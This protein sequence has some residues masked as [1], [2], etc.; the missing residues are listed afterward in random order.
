MERRNEKSGGKRIEPGQEGEREQAARPLSDDNGRRQRESTPL[1]G[2]REWG[3]KCI[4]HP[5]CGEGHIP[6]KCAAFKRL[7][8]A[9]REALAEV[10]GRCTRCYHSVG[11]GCGVHKSCNPPSKW[12]MPVKPAVPEVPEK[13]FPKVTTKEGY[14]SYQC[15]ITVKLVR[16][17]GEPEH[18]VNSLHV[19][20]EV[21][22]EDTVLTSS[23]V[24]SAG[25][26]TC[27]VKAKEVY[28]PLGKKVVSNLMAIFSLAGVKGEPIAVTAYVIEPTM[29]TP[30]KA[31]G[32][33]LL[34][35]RFGYPR[36]RIN[37][38]DTM[39][40]EQAVDL[41][42]GKDQDH[43]LPVWV[44]DSLHPEDELALCRV[45]FS[46]GQVVMGMA[47]Q[48][49]KAK[50]LAAHQAS[51]ERSVTK[52]R[53]DS[54][55]SSAT[56]SESGVVLHYDDSP[57]SSPSNSSIQELSMDE[58]GMDDTVTRAVFITADSHY[59]QSPG[60]EAYS[61]I[62]YH[63]GPT[64]NGDALSLLAGQVLG[65]YMVDPFGPQ[66]EPPRVIKEASA[67]EREAVRRDLEEQ[68]E[69][70]T[71]SLVE[72]DNKEPAFPG[73]RVIAMEEEES[74]SETAID[75]S[76][77]GYLR[78][79]EVMI[80][81]GCSEEGRAAETPENILGL[82][83][84]QPLLLC[85]VYDMNSSGWS[86]EE[87]ARYA[88]SFAAEMRLF[89]ESERAHRERL[90]RQQ[91]ERER[92][93]REEEERRQQEE[94]ER[95]LREE[96][97]RRQQEEEERLRQEREAERLAEERRKIQEKIA[98]EKEKLRLA[99]EEEAKKIRLAEVEEEKR[100]AEALREERQ[101]LRDAAKIQR[102]EEKKRA[103]KE[104]N[105]GLFLQALERRTEREAG[106]EASGD[107][108]GNSLE[109]GQEVKR[110]E[111][112]SNSDSASE[113][114]RRRMEALGGLLSLSEAPPRPF[115][116][117][118]V[119]LSPVNS[120]QAYAVRLLEAVGLVSHV[121]E[122]TSL[123]GRQHFIL[124]SE[125]DGRKLAK[126]K[127]R[128]AEAPEGN[129]KKSA[130]EGPKGRPVEA[131]SGLSDSAASQMADLISFSSRK[132]KDM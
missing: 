114:N 113:E 59:Q 47:R 83:D 109:A 21:E 3:L 86:L 48:G 118:T 74:P 57:F 97:E 79:V 117:G 63:S 102:E 1:K 77:G 120:L 5:Y 19:L 68:Q 128:A 18:K 28:T 66:D 131:V 22:A 104:D 65:E 6:M 12:W 30:T 40:M 112:Q 87:Q 124:A 42:I 110:V 125:S 89:A 14:D 130:V 15:R 64:D 115:P 7:P 50:K 67:E 119:I 45:L 38:Q 75:Y 116:L 69:T 95:L 81:S 29:R 108:E 13:F 93:Q 101:R 61:P 122:A 16:P 53:A 33:D 92:L 34:R 70:R 17:Q 103:E 96:E 85:P 9:Q 105:T 132:T 126:G 72:M 32:L 78:R 123:Q 107:H 98:E 84:E 121:R 49:V 91:E 27:K 35:E 36:I 31:R 23:V 80:P 106:V 26:E 129:P 71:V 56:T 41:R 58:S 20:M 60:P 51:R 88:E 76:G 37:R 46:P 127:R 2:N 44:R 43:L 99:E 54:R 52:K 90:R 10:R 111:G 39:Q 24:Q 94:R 4:I 11:V 100:K 82:E 73:R 62:S 8:L 25:L 55:T